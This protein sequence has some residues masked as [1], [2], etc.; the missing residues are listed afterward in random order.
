MK[1][2]SILL[3]LFIAV[4]SP[5]VNA[6]EQS[7]LVTPQWLKGQLADPNLVILQVNFLRLDYEKEHIVGARFLWPG[8]LAPDSPEG[9]FNAPDPEEATEILQRLGISANSRIVLCHTGN[10]VSATA[11]MFLTLE[12]LGLKGKVSFLNGGL[13]AWKKE[14]YAVTSEISPVKRG[15]FIARPAGLLVD[16]AYVLDKLKTE[17]SIVV[18]A[19]MQSFYDGEP[20]GYPRDGHIKGA[21]N[22]PFTDLI[23]T[24]N[25]IKPSDSLQTYFS[26]AVPTKD[27]ELVTYCFIGQTASVVYMAGRILGYNMKLYDG[28]MQE[29]SRIEA[30]PMEKSPGKEQ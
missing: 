3:I 9:N 24:S 18:D 28:S 2:H 10:G 26:K 23:N 12:H 8:W 20:T 27:K 4:L 14:G 17:S 29:W 13:E 7:I 15:N 19:R 30:C 21:K 22:I 6:Q 11:R 1:K 5:K 25:K 16:K